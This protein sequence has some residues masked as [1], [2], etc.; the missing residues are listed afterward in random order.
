MV[1]VTATRG[2]LG[3]P[4]LIAALGVGRYTAWVG[5]DSVAVPASRLAVPAW[6]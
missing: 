5:H 2:E 6:S 1:C 3:T 4:G